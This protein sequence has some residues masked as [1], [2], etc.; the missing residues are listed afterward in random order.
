MTDFAQDLRHRCRNPKC[1]MKL[2]DPVANHHARRV[3]IRASTLSGALSA[4]TISPPNRLSGAYYAGV[5]NADLNTAETGHFLPILYLAPSV[6]P[7]AQEMPI[8]RAL[9]VSTETIDRGVWWP[10]LRS[11]PASIIARLCRMGR[12]ANGLVV[13]G[14]EAVKR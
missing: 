5:Q 8:L 9:K 3:V 12:I 6:T 1:R 11:R 7:N 4:R 14:G 13:N 2:K 10:V